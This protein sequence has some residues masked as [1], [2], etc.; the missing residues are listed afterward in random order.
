VLTTRA[1][2]GVDAAIERFIGISAN[3]ATRPSVQ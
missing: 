1:R 2:A 3:A